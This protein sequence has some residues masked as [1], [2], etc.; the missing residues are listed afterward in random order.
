MAYPFF[1]YQKCK[2]SQSSLFTI[3]IV[4]ILWINLKQRWQTFCNFSNLCQL[5][6]N[7]HKSMGKKLGKSWSWTSSMIFCT[8]CNFQEILI[9]WQLFYRLVT[10]ISL[11]WA[12]PVVPGCA[13]CAMAHP[14]FGRSV[15]PISTRGD[16]LCPP[17]YYWHNRIFKPSDG[18]VGQK[19]LR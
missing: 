3:S 5:L 13:G 11:L 18:P 16:R 7:F 4:M 1:W 15:N 8:F 2:K 14:D 12:R 9:Y 17:N 6:S 19:R 10:I